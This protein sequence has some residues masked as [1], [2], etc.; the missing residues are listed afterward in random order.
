MIL[1][2]TRSIAMLKEKVEESDHKAGECEFHEDHLFTN[3][4]TQSNI[5]QQQNGNIGKLLL[6]EDMISKQKKDIE[7]STKAKDRAFE[8]IRE[9]K[10]NIR[11]VEKNLEEQNTYIRRNRDNI[12][13]LSKNMREQ[14]SS[15]NAILRKL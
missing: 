4:Q 12:S 8:I 7:V 5:Q 13:T 14:K 10:Y 9:I 1:L 15:N 6:A 2:Q 3:P 11:H